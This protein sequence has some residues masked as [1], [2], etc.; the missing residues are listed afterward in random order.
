MSHL[1][2]DLVICTY[3]NAMYLD[4][5]LTAIAAQRVS[6]EVQWRV[7]VVDNNCTDDTQA[8]VERHIQSGKIPLQ[9]VLEPKQGLTHARLCGVNNT[10]GDWIAFV[11][12]D[13]LLDETWVEQAAD[14]AR[15]HPACG[16]FG[17][18]VILHWETP[19]P[20]FV[21][22]FG[23][24][25]AEQNHGD[26]PNPVSCLVGAGLIM[27]RLALEET[28]WID[29]QFMTDRVGK[30]LVSGGD[31]ELALRLAAQYPLWYTPR[32]KLLHL[33][34]ARRT[35]LN[36]LIKMNYGLGTSQ[37]FG[38]SMLYPKS[39]PR[40]FWISIKRTIRPSVDVLI[41]GLKVIAQKRSIQEVLISLS[42]V[43]GRWVG[44][45]QMVGMDQAT[46]QTLLGCAATKPQPHLSSDKTL[47]S[48]A[49]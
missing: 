34:P 25:F 33:I 13:C 40:W 15:S 41:T 22:K 19:P 4:R 42:F 26:A 36:Y 24:S 7:L 2:I 39:Y 6:H 3:N 27:R 48:W 38:D 21:L 10:S 8:V 32:C 11:D 29:K 47:E 12:D 17:G 45:G 37:I 46:R 23:Y 16:G 28:G 44:I 5:V 49:R 14:F 1:S 43:V 18:K 30:K 35:S 9:I 31:V 20:T